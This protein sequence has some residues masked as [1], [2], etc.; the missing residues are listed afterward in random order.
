MVMP[1]SLSYLDHI[2]SWKYCA[3]C[4]KND[5]VQVSHLEHTG[6]G[7]KKIRAHVE[8]YTAIPMCH[9]CHLVDFHPMTW[10]EFEEKHVVD[11]WR[12]AHRILREWLWSLESIPPKDTRKEPDE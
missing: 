10:A 9:E 11:L 8:H 3:I 7:S 5:P 1:S 12:L 6:I 2:R 4:L